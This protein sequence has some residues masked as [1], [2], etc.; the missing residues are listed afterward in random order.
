MTFPYKIN[1]F[2]NK[3]I[4]NCNCKIYVTIILNKMHSICRWFKIENTAINRLITKAFMINNI[5]ASF[6]EQMYTIRNK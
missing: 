5:R 1:R 2:F 6:Y 3:I 4:I